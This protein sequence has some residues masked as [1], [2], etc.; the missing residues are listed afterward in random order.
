MKC[1]LSTLASLTTVLLTACGTPQYSFPDARP[2]NAVAAA[3]NAPAPVSD[4]IGQVESAGRT[5]QS[6]DQLHSGD[7]L[8]ISVTGSTALVEKHEEQIREDGHITPPLL[9]RAITAAGKTIGQLQEE[10]QKMYVPAYFKS[11]TVTIKRQESYFFVGGRVRNPGQ[12][13]YLSEMTVLKAIQAAGDFDEYANRRKVQIIRLNGRKETINC[14]KAL[15]NPKLDP[16]IYPGDNII[17]PQR[18]Y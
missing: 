16:P 6:F 8:T 10:L 1:F 18:W 5:N 3:G 17:V 14:D 11:A 15:K 7:R 13:V 9:G 12:R 2:T 4:A